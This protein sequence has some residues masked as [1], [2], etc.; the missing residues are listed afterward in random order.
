MEQ[1]VDSGQYM[2]G[3]LDAGVYLRKIEPCMGH[4]SGHVPDPRLRFV[5][6]PLPY[7]SEVIFQPKTDLFP[8]S[9]S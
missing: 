1:V 9:N 6:G 7:Q 4:D 8:F 5:W 2:D 3:V